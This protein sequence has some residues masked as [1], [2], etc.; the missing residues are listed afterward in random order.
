MFSLTPRVRSRVFCSQGKFQIR[1]R[2]RPPPSLCTS[3]PRNTTDADVNVES[4]GALFASGDAVEC[5]QDGGWW[6]AKVLRRVLP[7]DAADDDGEAA[8][9]PDK[10][11]YEVQMERDYANRIT[12]SAAT[13]RERWEYD[14]KKWKWKRGSAVELDERT[15]EL[16]TDGEEGEEEGGEEHQEEDDDEED[17]EEDDEEDEEHAR[18]QRSADATSAEAVT[19][20]VVDDLEA[21]CRLVDDPSEADDAPMEGVGGSASAAAPAS[22]QRR[23]RWEDELPAEQPPEKEPELVDVHALRRDD[24]RALCTVEELLNDAFA[25]RKGAGAKTSNQYHSKVVIPF[26]LT[27][28]VISHISHNP[29]CDAP[30]PLSPSALT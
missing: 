17:E 26:M 15:D 9:C 5:K 6:P 20:M 14:G 12:V 30:I 16:I 21:E 19:P 18:D 8:A 25:K 29:P 10:E 2:S 13:L 22:A 24:P 4:R 28:K 11:L 1:P 27:N 7:S 3:L 23:V